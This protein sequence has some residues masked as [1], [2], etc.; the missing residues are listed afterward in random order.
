MGN[1]TPGATY[2][3]ESPDGGK[4]VYARELGKTEKILV[5][6]NIDSKSPGRED[7]DEHK[8]FCDMRLEAKKNPALQKALDHAIMIFYL[9]K[10]Y[11][12]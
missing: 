5:G 1:L 11:G 9:T 4:T 10:D 7:L 6:Y 2:V 12:S 8:L 3:Y